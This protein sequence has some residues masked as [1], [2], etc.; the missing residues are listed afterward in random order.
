MYVRDGE[1]LRFVTIAVRAVHEHEAHEDY[2]SV[3]DALILG[4]KL[5][6]V[7]IAGEFVIYTLLWEKE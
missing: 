5:R 1:I 7:N 4:Y 3:N 6:F 2:K